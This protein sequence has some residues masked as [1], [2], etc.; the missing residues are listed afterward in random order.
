MILGAATTQ[1]SVYKY[2]TVGGKKDYSPTAAITG[3]PAFIEPIDPKTAAVLDAGAT[4]RTYQGFIQSGVDIKINDKVIDS[5]NNEYIVQGLQD[6]S[7]NKEVG[8][9]L[10]NQIE[11]ILVKFYDN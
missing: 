4:W 6:F 10:S 11:L 3:I 2:V 9:F 7:L 5:E 1:I 8:S